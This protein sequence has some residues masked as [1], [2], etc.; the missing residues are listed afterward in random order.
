MQLGDEFC[1]WTSDADIQRMLYDV[2]H[3]LLHDLPVAMR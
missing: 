2:R 3:V 1:D